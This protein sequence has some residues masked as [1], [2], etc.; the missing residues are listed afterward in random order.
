MTSCKFAVEWARRPTPHE[1]L[2]DIRVN[3]HVHVFYP[4]DSVD[5]I[6]SDSTTSA[7]ASRYINAINVRHYHVS[8]SLDVYHSVL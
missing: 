7:V 1:P 6:V 8:F 2:P 4:H 5:Q 3:M